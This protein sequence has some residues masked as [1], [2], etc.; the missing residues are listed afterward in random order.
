MY[1]ERAL[2]GKRKVNPRLPFNPGKLPE[3]GRCNGEGTRP[4]FF[5]VMIPHALA[6]WPCI[7]RKARKCS[8]MQTRQPLMK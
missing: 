4:D 3:A 7:R 1:L 6:E 8:N 2:D 5:C